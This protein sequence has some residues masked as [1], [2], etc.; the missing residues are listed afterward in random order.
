MIKIIYNGKIYRSNVSNVNDAVSIVEQMLFD[1]F[2]CGGITVK[3]VAKDIFGT[4]KT[5]DITDEVLNM[6]A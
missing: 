2:K 5:V 4:E 1:D 3:V 6:I